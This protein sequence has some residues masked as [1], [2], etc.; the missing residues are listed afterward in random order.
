MSLVVDQAVFVAFGVA[1]VLL[2]GWA[3]CRSAAVGD[4]P[5]D[6]IPAPAG[7]IEPTTTSAETR[8]WP[9]VV[10]PNTAGGSSHRIRPAGRPWGTR[11]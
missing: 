11:R 5:L 6:E 10:H 1:F 2:F 4:R 3:L 7:D 9:V 8:P